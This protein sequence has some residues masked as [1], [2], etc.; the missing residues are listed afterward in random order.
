MLQGNMGKKPDDEPIFIIRGKD[1]LALGIV[2]Q[3]IVTAG[4][5]GVNINKINEAWECFNAI[6]VFQRDHHPECKIPD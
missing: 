3:W 1:L 2:L 6:R 5:A 4:D